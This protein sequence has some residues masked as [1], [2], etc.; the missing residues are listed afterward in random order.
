M[1]S[2]AN[3][4]RT[5]FWFLQQAVTV[6][7]L[8]ATYFIIPF[9]ILAA[10]ATVGFVRQASGTRRRLLSLIVGLPAIWVLVG[11]WGG[12]FWFDWAHHAAPNSRWIQYPPVAGLL[13][14]F[15]AA[16]YFCFCL[17]GARVFALVYSLINIYFTV[18]M[19]FLSEMAVTGEWL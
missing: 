13:F 7:G 6:G 15:L 2:A 5:L 16:A 11:L 17:R 19:F 1:Q 10:L 3:A 9:T 14:S 8:G 12:V 4:F 18:T